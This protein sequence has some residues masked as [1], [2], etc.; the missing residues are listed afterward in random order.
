MIVIGPVE[1]LFNDTWVL[2]LT[3]PVDIHSI[4]LELRSVSAF[5]HGLMPVL[6]IFFSLGIPPA[7]EVLT[8]Q[9]AGASWFEKKRRVQKFSITI[10]LLTQRKLSSM[11]NIRSVF[12][13]EKSSGR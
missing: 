11:I 13:L 8:S 3:C 10:Q 6:Y 12:L 1:P 2:F 7:H 4:C 5:V 9:T